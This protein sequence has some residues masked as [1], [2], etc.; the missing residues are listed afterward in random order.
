MTSSHI[1]EQLRQ[2]TLEAASAAA[3]WAGWGNAYKNDADKAAVDAMDRVLTLGTVSCEVGNCEGLKDEAPMLPV[4]KSYNPRPDGGV[5]YTFVADP[6]EGTSLLANDK[7]GAMSVAALATYGSLPEWAGDPFVQYTQKLVVS[8]AIGHLVTDGHISV[9]GDPAHTMQ[10]AAEAL[11]IKPSDLSVA[12]LERERN[13]AIIEAAQSLGVHLQMLPGGDVLPALRACI[14]NPDLML[15]GSGGTPE[16]LLTAIFV[17]IKG[18]A[19]HAKLHPQNADQ[20]AAVRARGQHR[21]V[22]L[23]DLPGAEL[24]FAAAG[25]TDSDLLRGFRSDPETGVWQPGTYLLASRM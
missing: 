13:R 6:I 20:H 5:D 22:V 15:Y 19:M 21:A 2:V 4:G 8:P 25:I 24:H 3:P 10:T 18:G 7:P 12:V 14:K 23:S 16:A 9:D 17:A 11:G 1:P